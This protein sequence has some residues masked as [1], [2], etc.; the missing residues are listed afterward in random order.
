[1]KVIIPFS[2]DARMLEA[3]RI[4]LFHERVKPECKLMQE[5][6]DYY[7]LVKGLWAQGEPFII[8]E[9]DIVPWPGALKRIEDCSAPW[10]TF[11][12]RSSAGW[13]N[14]GLGIVKFDPSRLP[15]IFKEDFTQK[16][17]SNLDVQIA[18]RLQANGI[19]PCAHSPAVTNLN[20]LMWHVSTK[21]AA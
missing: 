6:D 3:V 4:A 20:P 16:H 21:A 18:R 14:D 1:M 17:W 11:T 8:N 2:I 15:N 13:I 5:T 12:Y 10:C 19:Q 9:H 7:N